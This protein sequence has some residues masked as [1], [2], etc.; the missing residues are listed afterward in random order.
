METKYPKIALQGVDGLMFVRKQEIL[1]ALAN[2]NYTLVYL[3]NGRM[4]KVLRKLKEVGHLLSDENFIRIHR[5]HLI[6]LG[7]VI[8]FNTEHS[9]AVMMSNGESLAVARNRKVTFVEKFT[10]I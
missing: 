10:R 1:Y 7:H 6:N 2:G 9:E 4:V 8:K 5:S 3:T